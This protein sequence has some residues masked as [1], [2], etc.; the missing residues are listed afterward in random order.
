MG[1]RGPVLAATNLSEAADEALRQAAALA[2]DI[3]A[4]YIVSHV[5]P[6]ALRVR[7]LF[8]Q[9]A[10][11]D[12]PVHQELE[13][14]AREILRDRIDAVVG[15]SKEPV[16]VEVESGTA[17]AGILSIADRIGAGL[18]V[19]G[20]GVT[21]QRV[22]R[23]ALCPVLVARPSP[24]GGGVLGATDFS[25]PSLPAVHMAADEAMRRGCP[26]RLL[27]C[28]DIDETALLSTAGLPGMIGLPPLAESVIEELVSATRLSVAEALGRTGAHGEPIVLRRPP[29]AGIIEA[30]DVAPTALIVVGT[31]GRTGLSRLALGSVAEHIISYAPCSVLVVPLHPS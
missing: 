8:P 5:L 1:I 20:P 29:A 13:R 2:S 12:A 27:H 23:S 19:V 6:E 18:I 10:G 7:V 31:R 22:A 16:A 11:V 24:T 26:L 17:H 28:L 25:D 21:A 4:P 14:R 15:R 30:A 3:G 9:E